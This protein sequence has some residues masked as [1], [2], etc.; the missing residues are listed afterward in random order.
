[1]TN[2]GAAAAPNAALPKLKRQQAEET[3]NS[4]DALFANDENNHGCDISWDARTQRMMAQLGQAPRPR[5][6]ERRARA[7][8]SSPSVTTTRS[9]AEPLARLA[10]VNKLSLVQGKPSNPKDTLSPRYGAGSGE[11][12]RKPKRCENA[13]ATVPRK[14]SLG[15]AAMGVMSTEIGRAGAAAGAR[16]GYEAMRA[17]AA[18]AEVQMVC[19]ALFTVLLWEASSR[20]FSAADKPPPRAAGRRHAQHHRTV[21]TTA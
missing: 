14:R 8:S 7:R 5:D 19:G 21:A 4:E 18:T 15:M 6:F 17:L 11:E 10:A 2:A 3:H 12:D 16:L 20:K 9:R 13:K 1:M